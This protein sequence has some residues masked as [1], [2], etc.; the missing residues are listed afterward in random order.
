MT[1]EDELRAWAKGSHA[2]VAA[3]ELLL[4]AFNGNYA[5]PGNPW[6]IKEEDDGNLWIN[7]EAIPENLGGQSSGERR[8]LLIAA[9]LADVGVE[10]NLGDVLPGLD[11]KS[12]DLVLAAVAHAGG[13]HEHSDFVT[14]ADGSQTIERLSTLYPWP[15]EA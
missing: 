12:L 11:R 1:H 10:V 3:T 4:R 15:N 5:K 6:V 9:S 2:L 14:N 13:S 7:F 8:F